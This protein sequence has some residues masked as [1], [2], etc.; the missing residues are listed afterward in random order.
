[1]KG[2]KNDSPSRFP[3]TFSS[4]LALKPSM[5]FAIYS[6][7]SG[8][9]ACSRRQPSTIARGRDWSLPHPCQPVLPFICRTHLSDHESKGGRGRAS[10]ISYFSTSSKA[11]MAFTTTYTLSFSVV[12]GLFRLPLLLR[13][14]EEEFQSFFCFQTIQIP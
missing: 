11:N 14:E 1:M 3:L 9:P 2:L 12:T 8:R 5:C 4:G 6:H 13:V 10:F 7:L